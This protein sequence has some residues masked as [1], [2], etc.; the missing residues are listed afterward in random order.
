M[1]KTSM[2][3]LF[4]FICSCTTDIID[5]VVTNDFNK[6]SVDW[7]YNVDEQSLF[8]QIDTKEI[9]HS[10]LEL[11]LDPID[12]DFYTVVD[13][14]YNDII[15]GNGIYSVLIDNIAY[16][17]N[18]YV[19]FINLKDDDNI[20]DEIVYDINFNAPSIVVDSTYPNIPLTHSLSDNLETLFK[21]IIA[22]EDEDGRQDID[23][24]RF[25]IKKVDF[26]N[27]EIIDGDCVYEQVVDQEY[28][29]DPTWELN[30]IGLNSLSQ[31]V[32]KVEIPM[33]PIQTST[34]CGGFG[35]F[36]VKFEVKDQKGF[37]D[38]LEYQDIIEICAGECQ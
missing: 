33:K 19:L 17:D 4:L 37:I 28:A 1:N 6:E 10:S 26:Y 20:I 21:M 34:V 12:L 30:Y 24:I 36:K 5:S 27:A 18:L 31:Y 7:F 8:I 15:Q 38:V 23:Y 14:E 25:Y 22:I 3:M 32:Y 2:Y 16:Q 35:T 9:S 11:K 13:N 29:F